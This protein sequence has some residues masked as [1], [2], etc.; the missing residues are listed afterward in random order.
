MQ[1][2][3]IDGLDKK[4]SKLIMGNDNQVYFDEAAKLWDH[5]IEVGGNAFDNAY[6]YGQEG[7]MEKL[8]GDWHRK[9]N[10]LKE[11]VV[12]AKG[13]HTPLCDPINLSKQLTESLDRMQIETA[14]IYIMHRDNLEI[15]V[16]EFVDVLNEEKNKGRVKIFGGSNWTLKRF[17][18]ANIWAEENNKTKLSIL[19]NNLALCKMINPLWDGCISSN[20]DEIL[21]YLKDNQT[22]HLS[23]SSQGRGYFLQ[24]DITQKIED[25]ITSDE[26]SWRKPGEHSSGPLS[27]FDSDENRERKKRV[28]ELATKKSVESQNIAGAWPIHMKFPSFALIGPRVVEELDSSLINLEVELTEEE[29]NWLNLK[30]KE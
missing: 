30:N 29:V 5:W 2:D 12:I 10:N 8:F 9:R 7:S 19:N 25:K 24:D 11:L 23:W 3:S 16:D 6:V 21:D 14:D 27:C 13:A 4:I 15:P 20:D 28:F 17:K 26:S 22:A 1:Y 18:E